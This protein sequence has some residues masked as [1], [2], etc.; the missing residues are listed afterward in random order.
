MYFQDKYLKYK[1]KYLKLKQQFGGSKI[2]I[3]C[4]ARNS[5][6]AKKCWRCHK[7]LSTDTVESIINI[8][9]KS[10]LE[11]FNLK[12]IVPIIDAK[13]NI[14]L[15]G[16]SYDIY[17]DTPNFNVDYILIKGGI[18]YDKDDYSL[19]DPN[20]TITC[21]DNDKKIKKYRFTNPSYSQNLGNILYKNLLL[22]D[23]KHP[24]IVDSIISYTY[25]FVRDSTNNYHIRFGKVNDLAEIGAKHSIIADN[26]AIIVSGELA[27]KKISE[28]SFEY[29]ININSSK[30]KHKNST[31]NINNGK[32]K[33]YKL[34]N[35]FYYII[36]YNIA[37][38][39]F[40]LL[41]PGLNIRLMNNTNI[42][43]T[44]QK[45]YKY[46]PYDPT[47]ELLFDSYKNIGGITKCPDYEFIEKYNDFGKDNIGITQYGMCI[48]IVGTDEQFTKTKVINYNGDFECN[49]KQ[50]YL[51]YK[52]KYL[53]LKNSKI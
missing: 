43:L 41:N 34:G 26:D 23:L 48:D 1:K 42:R 40:K 16:Y 18:D 37:F 50:K 27:I 10:F 5:N 38:Q 9:I 31:I 33:D 30:M 17:G 22:K 36:M 51:K 15:D 24:D 44:D 4:K 32:N 45:E 6:I 39:L 52:N 2:C 3:N 53:S 25:L 20:W 35:I 28:G 14:N 29:I 12:D 46:D 49:I 7:K 8:Q 13:L 19:G 47:A 21:E 11:K